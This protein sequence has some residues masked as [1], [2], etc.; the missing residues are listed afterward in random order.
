MR[1][2]RIALTVAACVLSA[3]PATADAIRVSYRAVFAGLD[4]ATLQVDVDRDR[5]R[6]IFNGTFELMEQ[7]PQTRITAEASG[8]I[9]DRGIEP[10]L[11]AASLIKA[12]SSRRI[13]ITFADGMVGAVA[14]LPPVSGGSA[15]TRP[16]GRQARGLID[17]LSALAIPPAS[18]GLAPLSACGRTQRVFD[19]LGRYDVELFPSRIETT[20]LA[21]KPLETMVC[22]ARQRSVQ[23]VGLRSWPDTL[24]AQ[25]ALLWLAPLADTRLLLPVRIEAEL[26]WG[27]VLLEATDPRPFQ[28]A[29]RAAA[30]R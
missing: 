29:T 4:V 1:R 23:S 7:R 10:D 2:R 11:Y 30:L 5:Y 17:P 22:R 3:G 25:S 24:R 20:V 12:D 27:R 26:R 28:P 19:G 8:R 21:D 18:S 13:A 16:T 14:V 15:G 6:I 9:L